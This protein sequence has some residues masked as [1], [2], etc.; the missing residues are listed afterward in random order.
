MGDFNLSE[1][2][3]N[4]CTVSASE[5]LFALKFF[6]LTQDL[7][8]TQKVTECTRYTV[9]QQLSKLNYIFVD[10]ENMVAEIEYLAPVRASDHVGL[11]C[12]V[13]Y[14]NLDQPLTKTAGRTFWG[15]VY[16]AT[17]RLS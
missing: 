17:G 1:I 3:Y 12:K 11:I 5:D 4:S 9:G 6:I 2:E 13:R 15:S 10:E 14:K 7:Y 8:L 16:T